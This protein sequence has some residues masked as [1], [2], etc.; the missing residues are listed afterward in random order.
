MKTKQRVLVT[1]GAGF[2]GSHV[3]T[4]LLQEPG[5][6]VRIL[7]LPGTN[8][9]HL[10]QQKLELYTGNICNPQEIEIAIQNCDTILHLAAYANL[11][12]KEADIFEKINYVGTKNL[13]HSAKQYGVK[14]FI[15]ISTEMILQ[16]ANNIALINEQTKVP[17]NNMVGPYCTSKWL[18]E[19]AVMQAATD[20]FVTTIVTPTV[21]VGPGDRKIGQFSKLIMDLT[22]G[23]IKAYIE[24]GINLINVIDVAEGIVAATTNS[25]RQAFF[26]LGGEY[27]PIKKLFQTI[28]ML[29]NC[30]A[31]KMKIPYLVGLH[32]AKIEE[33]VC[34]NIT[35]K[36]PMATT[37]G[38]KAARCKI[39]LDASH[40]IQELQLKLSPCLPAIKNMLHW[41]HNR[42]YIQVDL[43]L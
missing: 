17:F 30:K 21:P 18:A 6:Q 32:F 39:P 10:P 8:T 33:W 27:W 11:W 36:A 26:L 14:K 20:N 25:T 7:E 4:R 24:G 2:I 31:P 41:M 19:Q 15:H 9:Q 16:M 29:T 42:G 43:N 13:L 40:T 28:A 35:G 38:I 1:G 37:A 34:S 22:K 12:A 23:K 3:V 5:L